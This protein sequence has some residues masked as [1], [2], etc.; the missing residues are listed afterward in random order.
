MQI[1]WDKWSKV[2]YIGN[3]S[4]VSRLKEISAQSLDPMNWNLPQRMRPGVFCMAQ[5][6]ASFH[7]QCM[8]KERASFVKPCQTCARA[9]NCNLDWQSLVSPVTRAVGLHFK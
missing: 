2:L 9:E 6:F 7:E 8:K 3:E 4:R 5:H 1:A